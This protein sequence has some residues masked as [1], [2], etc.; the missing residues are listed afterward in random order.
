MKKW[1][2]KE[3][4]IFFGYKRAN[5]SK[6]R[7]RKGKKTETGSKRSTQLAPNKISA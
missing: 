7:K 1:V 2:L 3:K 6:K 4:T 5:R